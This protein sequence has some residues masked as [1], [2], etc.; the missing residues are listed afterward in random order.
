MQDG[1]LYYPTDPDSRRKQAQY[2]LPVRVGNKIRI[3][4]GA[5]ILPGVTIGYNFVIGAVSVVT[6]DVP[7]NAVAVGNPCRVLR[8]ISEEDKLY[9]RK[10][11]ISD[12]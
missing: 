1:R 7:A 5:I 8:E 2:N 6:K 12:L 11:E 4:A 10:G 3:G 9:Y